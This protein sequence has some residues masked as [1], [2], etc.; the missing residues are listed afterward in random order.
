[1]KLLFF[2]FIANLVYSDC[3]KYDKLRVFLRSS[4]SIPLISINSKAIVRR[5]RLPTAMCYYCVCVCVCVKET[6]RYTLRA[7]FAFLQ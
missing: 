1:M 2:S 5:T 3:A 6:V 7:E 4:I